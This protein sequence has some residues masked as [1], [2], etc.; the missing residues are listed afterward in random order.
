MLVPNLINE[1]H[2]ELT[3]HCNFQ[4]VHCYLAPDPRAELSTEEIFRLLEEMQSA[5]VLLLT[6]TGGEPLLR[7]DFFAIYR[8][9]HSL[10][11]LLNVFTNGSRLTSE[12]IKLFQEC[13]PQKVEITLNGFTKE[14]LEA[15]TAREGGHGEGYRGIRMLN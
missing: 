7:K 4:C 12:H 6:L 8:R 15:V 3:N 13:P 10:G 5:G 14:I 1:V 2:W 11:F 9:A